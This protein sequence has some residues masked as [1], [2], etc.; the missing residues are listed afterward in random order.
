MVFYRIVFN[1]VIG[2]AMASDP[3]TWLCKGIALVGGEEPERR[4]NPVRLT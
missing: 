3:Q 2:R 4:E 1:E